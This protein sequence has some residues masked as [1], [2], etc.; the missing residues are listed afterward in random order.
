[1]RRAAAS[2]MANVA[3]GFDSHSNLEFVQF[4]YYSLRSAS[5]LQSHLYI[6]H[7][8]G[9]LTDAQFKE[10]YEDAS[11]VKRVIFRFVEYLRTHKKLRTSNLDFQKSKMASNL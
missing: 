9:Y 3:E 2:I 6:A 11:R 5:E 7:D 4:L 10:L 1:M 8:Q